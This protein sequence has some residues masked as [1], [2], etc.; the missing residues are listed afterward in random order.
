MIVG[1]IGSFEDPGHWPC[2][3]GCVCVGVVTECTDSVC[4]CDDKGGCD[5]CGG[6]FAVMCCVGLEGFC[7]LVIRARS[8]A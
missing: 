1:G 4:V 2:C 7:C 5:D 8:C 6:L 3:V